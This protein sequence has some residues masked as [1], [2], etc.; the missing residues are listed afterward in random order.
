MGYG[1]CKVDGA[2][3]SPFL[4][5]YAQIVL[6]ARRWIQSKSGT[7]ASTV[8][9]GVMRGDLAQGGGSSSG[10]RSSEA[11]E[12][13]SLRDALTLCT[14]RNETLKRDTLV[15]LAVLQPSDVNALTLVAEVTFA[16]QL[17][18]CHTDVPSYVWQELKDAAAE[19]ELHAAV[20]AL[21]MAL[22][23]N[24]VSAEESTL[25][26]VWRLSST[27]T[28]CRGGEFITDYDTARSRC[29]RQQ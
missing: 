28:R 15:S 19:S 24:Q 16:S 4:R 9:S 22:N 17:P 14:R 7:D 12:T 13:A 8:V 11:L 21:T 1:A 25:R 29:C 26:V 3:H 20:H 2:A 5:G 27:H 6:Q 10:S 23:S 18:W